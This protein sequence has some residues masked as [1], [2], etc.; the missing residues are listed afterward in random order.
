MIISI[1]ASIWAQN[2]WDELILKN[3]IKLLEKEYWKE[4][5]II[6]FSYDYKNPFYKRS[7]II[8]KEY[9]PVW[10]KNPKNIFKNIFNFFVFIN[11]VIKSDLIVIWWGGIIYDNEKQTTKN[12]LDQW[13]FR[14]N[15]FKVFRKKIEFFAV[16]LNIKDDWNFNKIKTI[17][18]K[19]YKITVRDKYSYDLLKE[20]NIESKI[21]KDPVFNDNIRF[22]SIPP[23]QEGSRY[24]KYIIKKV[25]SY[26]FSYKDLED[27]DLEWKKV[28]LALRSWYIDNEEKVIKE[29]IDYILQKW[30]E[31]IL[32]PHS[33]HNID[34]IANDYKFLNKFLKITE[35]IRIINSMDKVYSKYIYKE[36]DLVLAMRLHS[37]ILSQ[38]Y[39]IPF[40]W[41]S[42]ST[43]TDEVLKQIILLK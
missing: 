1:F 10:I 38:I 36:M 12:P 28:A 22:S 19:A 14:T 35:K 29:I 34:E 26:D 18:S 37:I 30:W 33:F 31:V 13:I 42:Y 23:L 7:N 25:K 32:L 17:F 20:L 3:E 4:T 6:V 16:W 21:V 8:Y 40:I 9:F 39:N 5:K 43:K 41:I 27:I 11:S 15:I 2:L 24:K